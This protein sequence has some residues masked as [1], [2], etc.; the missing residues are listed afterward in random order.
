MIV[1]EVDLFVQ[2]AIEAEYRGW[3]DAHIREIISL[4]G[5]LGAEVFELIE[6]SERQ[7][8]LC[9]RY[10]LESEAALATYFSEHAPRLRAEGHTKF[11]DNF[12]AVRRVMKLVEL[13]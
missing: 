1:Y 3:L 11:G 8:A 13:Y 4:P 5:F 7:L 6:S 10:R 12:R 2:R 9:V